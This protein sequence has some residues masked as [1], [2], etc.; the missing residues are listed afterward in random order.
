M[1]R[2][3]RTDGL[4]VSRDLPEVPCCTAI[5]VHRLLAVGRMNGVWKG[6]KQMSEHIFFVLVR[7]LVEIKC[8]IQS[9][10]GAGSFIQDRSGWH[11]WELKD[12][13]KCCHINSWG[14]G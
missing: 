4:W 14:G 10:E 5:T 2:A 8:K 3:F 1:L 11:L 6:H 12:K 9:N 7:S 13:E